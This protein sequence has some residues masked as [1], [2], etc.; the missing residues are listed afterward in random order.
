LKTLVGRPTKKFF[1]EDATMTTKVVIIED[2]KLMQKIIAKI[3]TSDPEIE[4]VGIADDPLIARDLIKKTNP[5]VLTLDI[6]LPHM[7]GIT[8]LKNIMNLH[9][10]PV[11]MV[12]NLTEKNSII[13]LEA[14]SIG[15]VDYIS[16]PNHAD[17][18]LTYF[19]KTLP[20]IVKNAAK[21]NVTKNIG[22]PMPVGNQFQHLMRQSNLLKDEII[23]IGA[24]T[25]G[26]EA[27]ETVLLQ[28]PQVVPPIV[29]VQH[30]KKEF[31]TAFSRRINQVYGLA[32]SVP[33]D[34]GEIKPGFIYIAPADHHLIIKK[35]D[36]GYI[37]VYDN[38]PPINN[39][40]PSIDKLFES[41][42][43]AAG[44]N[45]IGVLL[46]G[47]GT[48]GAQG[49]KKIHDAGGATIAQDQESSVV[50]GMPGAAVKLNAVDHVVS[51]N[52]IHQAI[53]QAM[54]RKMFG[55]KTV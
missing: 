6:M 39:H 31:C 16:K 35:R 55:E 7:D 2:S 53:L 48:D 21:T 22:E 38:S 28:L 36:K 8:F 11:V 37:A 47:M 5:D 23:A 54:D 14:L 4:V 18:S 41:V 24:S 27:I 1:R 15:A 30:I 26:I 42:A 49:L 51:L 20:T 34:H 52:H 12:S 50:W 19:E 3:L 32:S 10:M 25:G 9:P 44:D 46:T 33:E 13:A 43:L 17:R 29:I 45:A 40:K